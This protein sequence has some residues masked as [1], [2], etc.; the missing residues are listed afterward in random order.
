MSIVG[1][2]SKNTKT[3]VMK[4]QNTSNADDPRVKCFEKRVPKW[5]DAR[6]ERARTE[7]ILNFKLHV[8]L[9][10]QKLKTRNHTSKQTPVYTFVPSR[11]P[12]NVRER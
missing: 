12:E 3:P 7:N 1:G 11:S 8:L 2:Q 4:Q 9:L 6:I 5:G 10:T